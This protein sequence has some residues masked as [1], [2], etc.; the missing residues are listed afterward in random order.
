MFKDS[1]LYE[2]KQNHKKRSAMN[3]TLKTTYSYKLKSLVYLLDNPMIN[4]L[5][6]VAKGKSKCWMDEANTYSLYMPQ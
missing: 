6:E 5:A 1:D 4:L 3:L 2:D